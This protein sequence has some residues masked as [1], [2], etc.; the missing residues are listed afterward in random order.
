[1]SRLS[2]HL[3]VSQPL[4]QLYSFVLFLCFSLFSGDLDEV[5]FSLF[6]DIKFLASLADSCIF[7]FQGL[8]FA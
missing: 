2:I 7:I 3:G 5:R 4:T 8:L 6:S 1:M